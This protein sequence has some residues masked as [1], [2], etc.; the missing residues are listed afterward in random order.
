MITNRSRGR[1]PARALLERA[2]GLALGAAAGR[3]PLLTSLLC[4]DGREMARLNRRFHATPGMTD[5]LSFPVGERD[6]DTGRWLVGEVAVCRPVAERE[7]RRRGL[8]V[9][10]ELLLYAVHGWLHL[11][12]HDD[13]R[14]ADRRRMRAAERRVLARLGLG[15]QWERMCPDR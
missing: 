4:V 11:A 3:R 9:E 8:A 14:P 7:A 1:L 12:G 6:E 2:A 15:G 5:V 10:A 13:H